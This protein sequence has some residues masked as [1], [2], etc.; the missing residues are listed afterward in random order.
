MIT[1]AIEGNQRI[2]GVSIEELKQ[3]VFGK[4]F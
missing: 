2:G 1:S 3:A 4:I